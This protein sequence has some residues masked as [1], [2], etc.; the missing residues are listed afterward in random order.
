MSERLNFRTIVYFWGFELSYQSNI[1][2][3]CTTTHFKKRKNRSS[4][5]S[6]IISS[7]KRFFERGWYKINYNCFNIACIK[8]QYIRKKLM[9]YKIKEAFFHLWLSILNFWKI[10]SEQLYFEFNIANIREFSFK[11]LINQLN[12]FKHI[13]KKRSIFHSKSK[14]SQSWSVNLLSLFETSF[15]S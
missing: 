10:V 9:M 15:N 13:Y 8:L 12:N 3:C 7:Q 5:L 14:I 4:L 6:K 1:C 2:V 11:H